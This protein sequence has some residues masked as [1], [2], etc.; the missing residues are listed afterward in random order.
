ML[1]SPTAPEDAIHFQVPDKLLVTIVFEKP[2]T[3]ALDCIWL[4]PLPAE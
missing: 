2:A 3:I 4:P 1:L